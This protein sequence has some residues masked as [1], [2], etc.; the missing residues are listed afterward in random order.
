MYVFQYNTSCIE[1]LEHVSTLFIVANVLSGVAVETGST[2]K[3]FKNLFKFGLI[4]ELQIW[5]ASSSSDSIS[6]C[7]SMIWSCVMVDISIAAG[8][9]GVNVVFLPL[10]LSTK[11]GAKQLNSAGGLL[12]LTF[13]M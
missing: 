8:V 10:S 6:G 1:F 13:E 12:I 9:E 4:D 7:C 5:T 3:I 11:S 2:H